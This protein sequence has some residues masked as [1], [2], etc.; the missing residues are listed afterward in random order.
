MKAAAVGPAAAGECCDRDALVEGCEDGRGEVAVRAGLDRHDLA[1]LFGREA[2]PAIDVGGKLVGDGEDALA[3]LQAQNAGSG[4]KAVARRGHHRHVVGRRPDQPGQQR[5]AALDLREEV[6]GRDAPGLRLAPQAHLAGGQRRA[7]QRRHLRR[8][9]P[10]HLARQ[11]KQLAL[12]RQYPLHPRHSPLALVPEP[13]LSARQQ[14]ERQPMRKPRPQAVIFDLGGVL[15]DWDPRYLYR[16]LFPDDAAAMERFLTEVWTHEWNLALDRGR[17]FA[18]ALPELIRRHPH[19]QA[20]IEAYRDRW[21]ETIGG[22]MPDS[23]AL[24]E[25]LHARAV[26]LWAITNWSAETFPLVRDDPTYAFLNLFREIYVSGS[27]RM[28]KPQ[29][30]IFHHAL[31]AI[32]LPAPSCLFID[33]NLHNVEAATG[34]GMETHHFRDAAALAAALR[35]TGLLG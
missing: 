34:L 29:P 16:Q 27:L 24:L 5:A 9:Q 13:T 26:P 1:A 32:G 30:E 31:A 11:V 15:I 3:A 2:A 7:R 23:V 20:R 17:P 14:P 18:Q 28:I 21:I 6:G 8:V 25:T 4:G 22:P 35:D 19:E 33:D 12:A 10:R